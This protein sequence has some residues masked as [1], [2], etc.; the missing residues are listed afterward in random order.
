[1]LH[2]QDRLGPN[3]TR[4]LLKM[5][6]TRAYGLVGAM[7]PSLQRCPDDRALRVGASCARL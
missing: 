6:R 5:I 2:L 3:L 7:I 4:E 1:M